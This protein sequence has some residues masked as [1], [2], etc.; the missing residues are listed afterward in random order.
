[1][2]PDPRADS[3]PADGAIARRDFINGMAIGAG[4]IVAGGWLSAPA[5]ATA[6]AAQDVPGYYPPTLTGMRGSHP[7]SYEAAHAVRDGT[8]SAP[9]AGTIAETYDLIIV[10]A[11]IGGLAA[12]HFYLARKPGARI[13]ILDNHDD[14]GGHAKRN[15]FNVDGRML[16]ANGGTWAIESPFPYSAV[17]HGLLTELGVDPPRLE[18]HDHHAKYY[19]GLSRAVFFDRETFGVDRLVTGLPQTG[20]GGTAGAPSPTAWSAFVAKTPLS[21][22]AQADIV[23]IET[24]TIDYLPGLTSDQKKERLSRMRPARADRRSSWLPGT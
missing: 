7:G 11:G 24:G 23:R 16:L 18:R 6:P 5:G 21:A 3:T 20:A 4:A 9:A 14:F 1:M 10:G 17:A 12:A 22:Q 15:E 8:A 19:R 13:L 2:K